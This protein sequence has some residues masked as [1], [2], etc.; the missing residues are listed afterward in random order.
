MGR[1]GLHI[2]LQH[3]L[4]DVAQ[5]A[6]RLGLSFFQCFL[7]SYPNNKLIRPTRQEIDAFV[8]F[9]QDH[10]DNIYVHGSYWINLANKENNGYRA[11]RRELQ[12]AKK[13]ACTHMIL[14]PG[15]AKGARDKRE[16]IDVLARALNKILKNEHDINIVLENAAHGK[17]TIGSDLDDF[18]QLLDKLDQPDKISFCI[19]TAHAY[20]AGY[21]IASSAGRA[22]FINQL[23]QTIGIDKIVM[24]HLNDT[25][26][27][28][29]SRIDR[30]ERA[31]HGK[32]G[33]QA[34]SAFMVHP[35]L[36][37]IP[38]VLEPQMITDNEEYALL[39]NVSKWL[40]NNE[41]KTGVTL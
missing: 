38:V 1:I 12:L 35:K 10:F 29:G 31:G 32:I 24:I 7:V 28:L 21:D 19:D 11:F 36:V 18:K 34:L 5:K 37:T 23:D 30:H 40:Q 15:S 3:S 25:Q 4:L 8:R 6:R 26:E 33:Q 13:L 22:T 14:H 2:R 27:K 20:A 17:L 41:K 39:H 16:G 9:R